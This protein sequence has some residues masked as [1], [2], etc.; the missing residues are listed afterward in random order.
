VLSNSQEK[1][2]TPGGSHQWNS[3]CWHRLRIRCLG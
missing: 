3:S 2:Q 1:S